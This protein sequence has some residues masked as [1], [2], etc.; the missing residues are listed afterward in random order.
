MLYVLR[1]LYVLCVLYV[2]RVPCMLYVLFT[3]CSCECAVKVFRDARPP[4]IYKDDYLRELAE[5]YNDSERDGLETP[6]KPEWY[7]MDDNTKEDVD[8]DGLPVDSKGKGKRRRKER[9]FDQA[10]TFAIESSEVSIVPSPL[11]ETVQ[12][13]C[14]NACDWQGC[15]Y[16]C[17]FLCVL[18]VY[19]YSIL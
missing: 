6:D 1:V 9:T 3:Y 17:A 11:R 19:V 7:F 14:Q 4:G 8:D 10:K 12:Q 5:R 16:L 15:V 18:H 2:L 13:I